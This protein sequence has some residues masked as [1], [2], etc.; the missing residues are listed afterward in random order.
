MCYLFVADAGEHCDRAKAAGAEILLDI[1]DA[2]SNGRG[3]SCR[4]L[5]GHVWNFGTY[6]PWKREPAQASVRWE[7]PRRSTWVA[8][9]LLAASGAIVLVG[10][11]LG[12]SDVSE[13]GLRLYASGSVGEGGPAAQPPVRELRNTGRGFPAND[14]LV[15]ERG[16]RE[17]ALSAE[18]EIPPPAHQHVGEAAEPLAAPS[19]DRDAIAQTQRELKD[20]RRQL[21]RE[22]GAREEAQRV[23]KEASV[24]LGLAE[25][26]SEEAHKQLAAEGNARKAA[27]IAAQE[28]RL[29]LGKEREAREAA[30]RTLTE[31]RQMRAR[32]HAAARKR[33]PR[34]PALPSVARESRS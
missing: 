20:A 26:A 22:R 21:I 23:A 9:S 17:A 14:R 5:D 30:Q 19:S 18:K 16:A 4:D 7:K 25:R 10:W 28:A 11:W 34:P 33:W 27:E 12:T 6:D 2:H 31:A 1:D 13:L 24:R 8:G 15:E 32:Q 29:E 3:Y